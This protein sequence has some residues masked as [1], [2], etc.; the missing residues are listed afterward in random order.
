MKSLG[1]DD[2]IQALI[3]Q[4][5]LFARGGDGVKQGMMPQHSFGSLAHARIGLYS[6]DL[7]AFFEQEM[8]K[9]ACP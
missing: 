7:R 6:E 9:N 8:R 1:G 2:E 4:R 3:L 5:G